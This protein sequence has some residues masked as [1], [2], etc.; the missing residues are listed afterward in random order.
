MSVAF[1]GGFVLWALVGDAILVV[2]LFE[3]WVLVA[4]CLPW[5]VCALNVVLYSC[6][7]FVCGLLGLMGA[8]DVCFSL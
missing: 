8:R 7:R 2:A 4:C 3:L 6:W 5:G 1:C